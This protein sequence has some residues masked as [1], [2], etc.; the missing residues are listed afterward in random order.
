ME[1]TATTIITI[2]DLMT[3]IEIAAEEETTAILEA[4]TEI[5]TIEVEVEEAETIETEIEIETTIAMAAIDETTLAT[6]TTMILEDLMTVDHHRLTEEETT[7]SNDILGRTHTIRTSHHLLR[8]IVEVCLRPH[9]WQSPPLPM[10][11]PM[12]IPHFDDLRRSDLGMI[13]KLRPP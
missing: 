6:K 11:R 7:P 13:W 5:G 1:T 4:E 12:M 9:R 10:L 8:M 3:M 2:L